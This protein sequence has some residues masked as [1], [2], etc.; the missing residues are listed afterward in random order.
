MGGQPARSVAPRTRLVLAV[1]ALGCGGYAM[2]QSLVV[3]A[4]PT[5]QHDLDTTPTGVTWVFT[6]YLLSA[7]VATPIAGRLGDMFGKKRTLLVVMA[8]L[9]GGSLI[10][11][12][13]TTL[14]VLILARTD[15]RSGRRDVPA[16]LRNHPRR[17]PA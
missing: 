2:L 17:V 6:A 15:S 12:L 10:A 5:L 11:A 16:R 7:S 8:G 9:A 14:P 13:A 1:L 3:P 4:L